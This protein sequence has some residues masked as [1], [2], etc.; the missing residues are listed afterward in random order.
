MASGQFQ[1]AWR[2]FSLIERLKTS[3]EKFP[4]VT[5]WVGGHPHILGLWNKTQ[6][7]IYV[8]LLL[9]RLPSEASQTFV[10]EAQGNLPHAL[11]FSVLF[12]KIL[13]DEAQFFELALR[14][15]NWI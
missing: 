10:R 13:Y 5:A 7:N 9:K 2:A 1:I 15:E 12:R 8:I 11:V 3:S 4:R 6:K 14:I